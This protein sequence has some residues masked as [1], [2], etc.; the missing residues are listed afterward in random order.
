MVP[1]V[2]ALC[3]QL[4]IVHLKSLPRDR[5][6]P[7]RQIPL[8]GSEKTGG[9]PDDDRN[10]EP[11]GKSVALQKSGVKKTRA[12]GIEQR[13]LTERAVEPAVH[14]R[15]RA[16]RPQVIPHQD[17]KA[18]ADAVCCGNDQWIGQDVHAYLLDHHQGAQ[19]GGRSPQGNLQGYL[20]ID[21]YLAG[22]SLRQ[23]GYG[24]AGHI[25]P[26]GHGGILCRLNSSLQA[27]HALQAFNE[28]SGRTDSSGWAQKGRAAMAPISPWPFIIICTPFALAASRA[29]S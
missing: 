1:L 27:V 17:H 3:R 8:P 25:G 2:T 13:Q 14:L 7:G 23:I 15:L 12:A 28:S 10:P 6:G 16:A 18:R 24:I 29:S 20:F 5:E 22:E 9:H 11:L 26:H 19:A 4:P 21:R